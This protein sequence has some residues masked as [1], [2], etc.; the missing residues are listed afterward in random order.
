MS[1]LCCS[2]II[3]WNQE[4][5]ADTCLTRNFQGKK[6]WH[7][8]I[9]NDQVRKNVLRRGVRN[10]CRRHHFLNSFCGQLPQDASKSKWLWLGWVNEIFM[11]QRA[12]E[13]LPMGMCII[14]QY[15]YS[16]VFD[17]LKA[18]C[19][20]YRLHLHHPWSRLGAGMSLVYKWVKGVEGRPPPSVTV[21]QWLSRNPLSLQRCKGRD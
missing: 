17:V 16:A 2:L 8:I 6:K 7:K 10:K 3:V 11:D 9:K 5:H 21:G 15:L 19:R 1:A 4:L 13:M 20:H 14:I 18:F 12:L